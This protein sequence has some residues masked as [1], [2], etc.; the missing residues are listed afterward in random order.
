MPYV[1]CMFCRRGART[2]H[3]SRRRPG[4]GQSLVEFALVLPV[5]LLILAAI[6]DFGMGLYTSITVTNAAREGARLGV[7]DSDTAD[8]EARV[9]QVATGLDGTRL[10]VTLTCR[11]PSGTTWVACTGT[12]WESGDSMIVRADYVYR[13]IW[14][15]AFGTQI[16]ITSTV[17]MRVE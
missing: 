12:L 2:H 16:P 13:M 7:V 14:P 3:S 1:G 6:V 15:L 5:F 10:T 17:E 4:R 8:I 11:E 9:R